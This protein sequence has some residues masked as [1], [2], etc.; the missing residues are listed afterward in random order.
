M[1]DAPRATALAHTHPRP[2]IPHITPAILA[3]PATRII[4]ESLLGHTV[5]FPHRVSI[6]LPN[7][8]KPSTSSSI[9]AASSFLASIA[10]NGEYAT[11]V[12]HILSHHPAPGREDEDVDELLGKEWYRLCCLGRMKFGFEGCLLPVHLE[13]VRVALEGFEGFVTETD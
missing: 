2:I 10:T 9:Y 5:S 3:D 11:T 8:E 1:I 7:F 6:E 4:D 12:S 13:G